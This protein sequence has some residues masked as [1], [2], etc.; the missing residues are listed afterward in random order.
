MY[1]NKDYFN[2]MKEVKG[3]EKKSNEQIFEER[4]GDGYIERMRG[5]VSPVSILGKGFTFY[6]T[7]PKK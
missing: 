1:A 6:F 7:I 4:F 3:K 2:L 5:E